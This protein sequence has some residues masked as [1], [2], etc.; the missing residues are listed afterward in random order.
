MKVASFHRL[1]DLDPEKE[2][3][4]RERQR[5]VELARGRGDTQIG[6]KVDAGDQGVAHR[7]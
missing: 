5:Q 6:P 1:L 2:V 7:K 3:R 4:L